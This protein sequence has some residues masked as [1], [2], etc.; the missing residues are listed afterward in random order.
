V[1]VAINKISSANRRAVQIGT[2]VVIL[3]FTLTI[4]AAGVH[5][6]LRA[7]EMKELTMSA[8]FIPLYYPMSSIPV[9]FSLMALEELGMICKLVFNKHGDKRHEGKMLS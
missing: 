7:Y 2:H 4:A 8:L 3:A 5:S 1:D 6:C 9:G